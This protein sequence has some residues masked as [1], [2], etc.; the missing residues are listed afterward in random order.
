VVNF[1]LMHQIIINMDE[2]LL[3]SWADWIIWIA[4]KKPTFFG[5]FLMCAWRQVTVVV[6]WIFLGNFKRLADCHSVMFGIAVFKETPKRYS[7]LIYKV[8]IIH[9]FWV[10]RFLDE[11]GSFLRRADKVN[12]TSLPEYHSQCSI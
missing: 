10:S 8:E 4:K 1:K 2:T 3:N 6:N 7:F 11:M 5:S 9:K 12:F